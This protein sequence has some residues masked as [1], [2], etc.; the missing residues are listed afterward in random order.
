MV[1]WE[2]SG[3]IFGMLAVE[4]FAAARIPVKLCLIP[5][6]FFAPESCATASNA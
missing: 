4:Q 3:V 2:F 6:A 1:A 5:L